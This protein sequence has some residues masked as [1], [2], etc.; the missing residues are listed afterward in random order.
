MGEVAGGG[1]VGQEGLV[2]RQEGVEPRRHRGPPHLEGGGG[3]M[4][5]FLE[6]AD[7]GDE[8]AGGFTA[9]ALI[10]F[11]PATELEMGGIALGGIEALIG[12]DNTLAL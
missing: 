6:P 12:Q 3:A 11:S 10:P 4:P 5:D 8:R 7:G 1:R 9:H 2:E